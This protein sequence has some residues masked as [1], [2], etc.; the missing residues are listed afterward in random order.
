MDLLNVMM[1]GI[2][3]MAAAQTPACVD[4]SDTG[5]P[6]ATTIATGTNTCFSSPGYPASILPRRRCAWRFQAPAGTTLALTCPINMN[7][8]QGKL[9]H[10]DN[11][12]NAQNWASGSGTY[13]WTFAGNDATIGL[14]GRRPSY[15]FWWQQ[16]KPNLYWN[17]AG[18]GFTCCIIANA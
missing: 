2:I 13:T 3:S 17:N 6:P 18:P 14:E 12:N 16:R 7:N 4:V 5:N 8:P 9:W 10:R 11:T 15:S 1:L